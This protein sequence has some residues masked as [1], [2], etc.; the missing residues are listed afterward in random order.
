M[1]MTMRSRVSM[2]LLSMPLAVAGWLSAHCLAYRLAAPDAHDRTELL[3]ATGH[4]YLHLEPLFVACGLALIVAGLLASVTEG[5][6]D[7]R[8]SRPSLRLLMLMPVLGFAVLE[9]VER[10]AAHD[11]AP[12]GA[13][14]EP[15][16]LIGLAL[17]LPFA[18]AAFGFVYAL[19]GLAHS[20]GRAL[21]FW[22]RPARSLLALVE[23]PVATHLTPNWAR[24]LASALTPGQGPRA[25]PVSD[26]P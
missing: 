6:R 22:M 16:F 21:R 8:R 11:A 3:S 15:T 12:Y 18:V 10:L 5:I 20:L 25:P 9:H 1:I 2:A 26:S 24:P 4:G 19:H 14:L 23:T 17:Q 13:A 7:R